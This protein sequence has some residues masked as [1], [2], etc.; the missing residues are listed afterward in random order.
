MLSLYG[1]V[2]VLYLLI[3]YAVL[4]HL[5]ETPGPRPGYLLVGEPLATRFLTGLK[6]LVI[7]LKGLFFPLTLSADYS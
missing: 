7:Y 3:R 2:A 4:G 6:I 1:G 5:L